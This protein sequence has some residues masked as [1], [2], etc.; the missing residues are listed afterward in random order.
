MVGV[1]GL[2]A[3]KVLAAGYGFSELLPLT[4]NDVTLELTLDGHGDDARVR[5]FLPVSDGRQTVDGEQNLSPGLHLSTQ[6]TGLAGQSREAIWAGSVVPDGT[7]VRYSLHVVSQPLRFELDSALAVPS[8]YPSAIRPY[9][10]PERAIQVDSPAIAEQLVKLGA[11]HGALVERLTRIYRFTSGLPQ[12]PFKGMTDALTAL[13]LGEAS[14]NGKSRLLV[15]LARRAG[16]PARLV[17]GLVMREGVTRTTHQWAEAYVGGHWVP[18]D[19]TNHHFAELPAH[20]LTL[21]YGD[22]ALFTHTKDRNVHYAYHIETQLVPSKH[23]KLALGSLNV[24][25]MFERLHLPMSLLR[26]LLMLPLGALV[27]VLCR[28]VIGMPTFGTFL[29]ALVA[30]AMAETGVLWGFVGLVSVL[31]VVS[32][33]R[34]ALHKLRLLHS[35]TLAI[36]LTL[37]AASMIGT[38]MLAE[39]LGL[40]ALTRISAFPIAVL[41]ITAE[42]FYLAIVE[43]GPLSALKHLLGTLVVIAACFV[44]MSSL[45]LQIIIIG[46]PEVLLLAVAVNL[47]LGRWVGMRLLE[48]RRFRLLVSSAEGVGR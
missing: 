29:P 31:A 16:I 35:P 45:A 39:R 6:F 7:S 18:L 13:R 46:F 11:D 9:L 36:L 17:G 37:V 1:A 47:Y 38:S 21:Y 14:C 44:V 26:T 25:A 8:T 2:V 30:A 15:A 4:R 33:G 19:A 12:R 34:A 28:N 27:V 10:E 5:T 41:A 22:E 20:Y 42:R 23:A 24:W 32:I 43:Q 48:H 3:Y 40:P